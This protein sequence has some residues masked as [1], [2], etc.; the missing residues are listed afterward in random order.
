MWALVF[1]AAGIAV[2]IYGIGLIRD[3]RACAHWPRVEGKVI[4]AEVQVVA[5]EKNRTTYAPD[6][7]YRYVVNGQSYESTRYTL[8]PRNTT[9][10]Q[11]VQAMLA[12]FPAGN[13][14]TVFYSPTDPA[15]SVLDVTAAG[16][17][18]AYALGGLL[19]LGV[20]VLFLK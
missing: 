11:Q 17:E 15:N 9:S 19:L 4:S 16:T 8:V 14:A 7:T 2:L 18:W 10:T 5:R 12:R 3:V 13:A 1:F 20:G 6:V